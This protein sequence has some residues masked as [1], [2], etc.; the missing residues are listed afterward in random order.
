M[1]VNKTTNKIKEVLYNN[2][3]I[4]NP[5]FQGNDKKPVIH[6]EGAT[7][8]Q[9]MMEELKKTKKVKIFKAGKDCKSIKDGDLVYA[10]IQRLLGAPRITVEEKDYFICREQDIIFVYEPSEDILR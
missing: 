5:F 1:E 10:E 4:E 2:V 8:E 9:M 7:Q 3:L 6:L